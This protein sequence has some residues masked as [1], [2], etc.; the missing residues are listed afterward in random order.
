MQFPEAA[1]PQMRRYYTHSAH[2]RGGAGAGWRGVLTMGAIEH[3]GYARGGAH[4]T[5]GGAGALWVLG[6]REGAGRAGTGSTCPHVSGSEYVIQ[7][8]RNTTNVFTIKNVRERRHVPCP[9]V[10]VIH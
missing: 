1:H 7:R 2:G 8:V 9:V 5:R 3:K 6:S 10:S 4:V